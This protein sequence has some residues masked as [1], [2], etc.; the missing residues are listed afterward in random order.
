MSVGQFPDADFHIVDDS[1]VELLQNKT[2]NLYIW[3][4]ADQFVQRHGL[5]G[6]FTGIDKLN[7]VVYPNPNDGKFRLRF[8]NGEAGKYQVQILNE[9][10]QVQIVKEI[11]IT[12]YVHEVEIELSHLSK[13][14]YFV[15]V[16]DGVTFNT[17]KIILK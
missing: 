9:L 4:H 6:F 17:K 8:I 2:D 13:G 5:D 3:C 12:D 16:Y 1:F 11:Y 7:F 14:N 15:N 10:G